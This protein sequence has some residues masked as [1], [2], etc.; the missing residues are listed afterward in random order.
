MEIKLPPRLAVNGN[1]ETKCV[2][3]ARDFYAAKRALSPYCSGVIRSYPFISAFG[4]TVNVHD[5]GDLSRMPAVRAIAAHTTVTACDEQIPVLTEQDHAEIKSAARGVLGLRAFANERT[6]KSRGNG[7]GITIA[8]IDTGVCAHPDFM[9]PRVR[10]KK[11]VDLIGGKDLPYDDNGHGSAVAGIACG[12][13]LVSGGEYRGSAP[14]ADLVAIKALGKNGEGSA[15]DILEAMQWIYINHREYNIK[16]V[17]MSFGTAPLEEN[18]P[19]AAGAEAL[20]QEGVTVVASAGNSGPS[21]GSVTSPAIA[22]DVIAVGAYGEENG[23][24]YVPDFSSRGYGDLVKPEVVALGVD[25]VCPYPQNFYVKM[26]G[27]SMAAPA[28]AGLCAGL[29]AAE[30]KATPDRIKE[31]VAGSAEKMIGYENASGYGIV[32]T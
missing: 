9:M 28:V 23:K 10:I 5:V 6:R 11:F 7:E 18:D 2:V 21:N 15:F 17:C 24:Y 4:A 3:F 12:N 1:G 14:K 31:I 27:T 20:W 26:S 16:V 13:G 22:P 19:L 25:V 32:R 8:V 30:P 29:F